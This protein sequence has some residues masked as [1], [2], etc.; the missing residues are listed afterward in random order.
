VIAARHNRTSF[1]PHRVLQSPAQAVNTVRAFFMDGLNMA[2]GKKT[3]FEVFKR[4]NFCC[5]YC[6]RIPP[7]VVLEIDHVEPRSKGGSDDIDNLLTSCKDCNRGKRDGRLS[8]TATP[9]IESYKQSVESEEQLKA[10]RSHRAAKRR[11]ITRDVTA[12]SAHFEQLF[13][14]LAFTEAFKHGSVKRFLSFIDRDDLIE[15][16]DLA[17][18]KFSDDPDNCIRYFCGICWTIR[19]RQH[20]EQSR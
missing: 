18:A 2:I 20:E 14:E 6:G 3:R 10:M 17:F 1:S 4:D 5:M 7:A 15:Y 11:R 19:K 8:E 9:L 13:P 16:L 12:V